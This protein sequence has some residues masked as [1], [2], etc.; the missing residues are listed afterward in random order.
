M[1]QDENTLFSLGNDTD[2]LCFEI[3]LISCQI[4]YIVKIEGTINFLLL[5]QGLIPCRENMNISHSSVSFHILNCLS[6]IGEGMI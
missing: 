5:C 4:Q 2:S 1:T 3:S 6:V